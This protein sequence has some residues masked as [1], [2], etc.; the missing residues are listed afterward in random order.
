MAARPQ[1]PI[2]P[3][4][5]PY[6]LE[7][8]CARRHDDACDAIGELRD[9]LLLER[10][11]TIELVGRD[12]KGGRLNGLEV[13]VKDMKAEDEKRKAFVLKVALAGIL[14]AGGVNALIA[15]IKAAL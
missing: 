8:V 11:M 7:V 1:T 15:A 10:E 6:A 14:S 2:P 12:G 5:E 3:D 4:C 9:G 13:D